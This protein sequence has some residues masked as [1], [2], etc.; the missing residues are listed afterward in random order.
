MPAWEKNARQVV[1]EVVELS[2]A[3][4]HPLK[5]VHFSGLCFHAVLLEFTQSF[6]P[7]PAGEK[8]KLTI[9]GLLPK[10][11]LYE[12]QAQET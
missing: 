8:D 7:S 9:V 2:V 5:D 11:S 3:F 1:L 10:C 12:I 4:P 6:D